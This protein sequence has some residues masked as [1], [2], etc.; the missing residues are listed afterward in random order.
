MM[1]EIICC[2]PKKKNYTQKVY[3]CNNLWQ[4]AMICGFLIP[5]AEHFRRFFPCISISRHFAESCDPEKLPQKLPHFC[6]NRPPVPSKAYYSFVLTRKNTKTREASLFELD[7]LLDIVKNEAFIYTAPIDKL[8]NK[9]FQ[10][11]MLFE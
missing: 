4:G 1:I 6:K 7:D 9:L 2:K 10:V 5:Q 11:S 8:H 3:I